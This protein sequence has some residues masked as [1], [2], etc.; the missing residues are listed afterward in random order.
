MPKEIHV[1]RFSADPVKALK[2]VEVPEKHAGPDEILI[3]VH[4]CS[5]SFPE[6]LLIQ[7]KYQFKPE[8][9][10]SPGSEVS[11]VVEQVGASVTSIRVGDR[12]RA[13]MIYG[14]FKE[15]VIATEFNCVKIPDSLSF[16]D[17]FLGNYVTS[18]YSLVVRG[19]LQA[20]ETVLVLGAAGGLGITCIELCKALGARVI[21]AASSEAKLAACKR[22]GADE[23]INYEAPDWHLKVKDLTMGR[24][25]D[26][27][28]DPVGDRFTEPAV[29][30]LA[31]GGRL[32]VIGFAAGD[33]PKIPM[34]LLLLKGASAVGVFHGKWPAMDGVEGE[35]EAQEVIL[36]LAVQ[37]QIRPAASQVYDFEEASVALDDMMKRRVIGKAVLR[38]SAGAAFS[39]L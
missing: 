16:Q 25:V 19:R 15:Q 33:I 17:C 27:C 38:T 29:R 1:V 6:T 10:F 24:G 28:F 34:N 9:P 12:V 35:K 2:I 30:C 22:A 8:I 5:V 18:Y 13:G 37:K 21:A 32:L 23:L 4:A 11:G 31:W 3:R 26:I 14:G 20:G 36:N 7:N 39:K